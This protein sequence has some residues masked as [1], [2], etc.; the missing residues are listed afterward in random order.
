[1]KF[2]RYALPFLLSA[3]SFASFIGEQNGFVS[4]EGC[5]NLSLP[6]KERV[7]HA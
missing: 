6:Q 3:P 4:S 7:M 1:M 5:V 2:L